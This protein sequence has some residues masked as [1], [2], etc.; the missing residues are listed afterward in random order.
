MTSTGAAGRR[1]LVAALLALS[2]T[3]ACTGGSAEPDEVASPTTP[4]EV[5]AETPTPTPTPTVDPVEEQLA[6]LRA[7]DRFLE[8]A[9]HERAQDAVWARFGWEA[10]APFEDGEKL[11]EWANKAE[12]WDEVAP[13]FRDEC[14]LA[15]PEATRPMW[16]AEVLIPAGIEPRWS[17][18]STGGRGQFVEFVCLYHD[19]EA[20]EPVERWTAVLIATDDDQ[21][22][23]AYV[24]E[25]LHGVA[26]CLADGLDVQGYFYWSL[27]DNFEWAFGYGP[28]FGLVAVDRQTFARTPKDSAK[29][30]ARVAATNSIVAHR[31]DAVPGATYETSRK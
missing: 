23:I 10:F 29:W 4:P 24:R 12:L 22:R 1:R 28:R 9:E 2:W 18:K 5:A 3:A 25:A 30:F 7:T 11:F 19:E 27:L 14:L 20:E 6:E 8:L 17:N 13:P 21:Q 31:L 26:R 15:G 16:D